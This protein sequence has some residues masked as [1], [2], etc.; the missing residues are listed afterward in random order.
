MNVRIREPRTFLSLSTLTSPFLGKC[1]LGPL[2][3]D[4][5]PP[6]KPCLLGHGIHS[7]R[8]D[9]LVGRRYH[10]HQQRFWLQLAKKLRD[11]TNS[12]RV[13]SRELGEW[14]RYKRA[15]AEFPSGGVGGAMFSLCFLC[16][17]YLNSRSTLPDCVLRETCTFCES[18]PSDGFLEGYEKHL[19]HGNHSGECL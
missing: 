18:H 11:I 14:G 12:Q 3:A 7:S 5:A 15:N 9:F 1:L 10:P 8:T 19:H 2:P 17:G 4:S 6:R 16:A 13:A